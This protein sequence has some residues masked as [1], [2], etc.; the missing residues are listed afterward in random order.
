MLMPTTKRSSIGPFFFGL[1]GG[2]GGVC[3][4]GAWVVVAWVL[5][6][7]LCPELEAQPTNPATSTA[8]TRMLMPDAFFIVYNGFRFL[9]AV[10]G[11]P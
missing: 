11:N 9:I 8:E 1:G 3:G 2:G 6:L 4:G 5:W 7:E 10:M